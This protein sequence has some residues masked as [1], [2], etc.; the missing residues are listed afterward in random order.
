MEVIDESESDG[1]GTYSSSIYL[2]DTDLDQK[3]KGYWDVVISL[4]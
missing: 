2:S 1:D 3:R 4:T